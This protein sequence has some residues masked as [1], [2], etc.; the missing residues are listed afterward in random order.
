[1]FFIPMTEFLALLVAHILADFYFQPNDW[2]A[3]KRERGWKSPSLYAHVITVIALSY[4]LLGYWSQPHLAILLG[5]S[6]G[7]IDAIK[8][9][10]DTRRTTA[11]FIGDQLLHLLSIVITVWAIH[12]SAET[13]LLLMVDYLRKPAIFCTIAGVLLCLTPV[14]FLVGM[15]TKP[16]RDELQRLAPAAEDN[17]DN[18]GRWIGMSERLLI[19]LF[20]LLGQYSA[21]GFL[22]AAKSLLRYNDKHPADIPQSYISKK[23]EYV[24][25]GTLASYTCAIVIALLV[26][27]IRA[28]S[29]GMATMLK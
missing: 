28:E 24:L 11:W 25:V 6:H 15:F 19:F 13:S 12:Q 4:L 5:L 2:V 21:I 29:E 1:M 26:R 3:D 17:L 10:F 9:R 16:W 27:L 22:I 23:S 20:V 8:L 7:F 18:A 14:S